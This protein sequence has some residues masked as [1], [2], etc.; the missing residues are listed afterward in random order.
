MLED[1][2]TYR[3]HS[4]VDTERYIACDCYFLVKEGGS[5]ILF[6]SHV[7]HL[8]T[9]VGFSPRFEILVVGG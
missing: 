5:F 6:A 4:F 9:H 3:I 8:V 2:T 7:D 1:K